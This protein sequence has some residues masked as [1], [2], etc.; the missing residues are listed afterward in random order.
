VNATR[1]RLADLAR[2]RMKT[3]ALPSSKRGPAGST[4][5]HGEL[6]GCCSTDRCPQRPRTKTPDHPQSTNCWTNQRQRG[7]QEMPTATACGRKAIRGHN[8]R[9]TPHRIPGIRPGPGRS[10]FI[11]ESGWNMS[12]F[13]TP[14]TCVVGENCAANH[15]VRGIQRSV[16]SGHGQPKPLPQRGARRGLP[17]TPLRRNLPRRTLPSNR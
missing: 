14:R 5:H 10:S 13:P 11:A 17:L 2:G 8:G 4:D 16:R 1:R 15:P 6:A 3:N 9:A 7:G 12:R